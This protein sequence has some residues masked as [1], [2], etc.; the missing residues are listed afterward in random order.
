MKGKGFEVCFHTR[1]PFGLVTP[2]WARFV[3]GPAGLAVRALPLQPA[4][5]GSDEIISVC[6]VCFP[7]GIQ[8][9]FKLQN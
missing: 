6:A 7:Q 2:P 9:P 3:L 5:R 4:G 8:S 1:G